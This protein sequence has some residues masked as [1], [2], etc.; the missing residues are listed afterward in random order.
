M[1]KQDARERIIIWDAEK[2]GRLDSLDADADFEEDPDF[3]PG[4]LHG[5]GNSYD[6]W[7]PMGTRSREG[8]IM[9]FFVQSPRLGFLES[10]MDSNAAEAT[11]EL[12]FTGRAECV[13]DCVQRLVSSL[14]SRLSPFMQSFLF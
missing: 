13:P 3:P 14:T 12:V 11:Q 5:F 8:V 2:I 4:V 7:K 10:T 6:E 9:P 1:Q